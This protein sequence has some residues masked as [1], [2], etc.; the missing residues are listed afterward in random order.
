MDKQVIVAINREY[1]AGGQELAQ[2]LGEKLGIKVYDTN[3]IEALAQELGTSVE[4]LNKYDEKARNV[5]FA[6]QVLNHYNSNEDI[7][8]EVQFDFLRRRVADGESFV[9]LGRCGDEVFRD[10]VRVITV[11]VTSEIE[12]RIPF[13]MKRESVSEKEAKDLIKKIDKQRRTYHDSHSKDLEWRDVR[14]Y[15]LSIDALK[16]GIENATDVVAAYV[17]K[18]VEC[19]VRVK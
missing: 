9:L 6:R 12:K 1:G 5:L 11:Y 13:V 19:E 16:I 15:D 2:L 18:A 8:A 17:K 4:E 3:I 10:D 14:G 7:T